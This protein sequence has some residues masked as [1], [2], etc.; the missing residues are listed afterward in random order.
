MIFFL[1]QLPGSV[2]AI[3][4]AYFFFYVHWKS[5]PK[6]SLPV[7]KL[8]SLS[9]DRENET[10]VKLGSEIWNMIDKSVQYIFSTPVKLVTVQFFHQCREDQTENLLPPL[11]KSS[12]IHLGVACHMSTMIDKHAYYKLKATKRRLHHSGK[13]ILIISNWW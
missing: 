8:N 6:I 2:R 12:Q 1:E 9:S 7:S 10:I 13:F 4:D 5:K 3:K 11:H